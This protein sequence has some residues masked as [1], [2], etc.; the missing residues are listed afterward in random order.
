MLIP[1][2]TEEAA[3][4]AGKTASELPSADALEKMVGDLWK[5]DAQQAAATA[6]QNADETTET[7]DV[8]NGNTLV[9]LPDKTLPYTSVSMIFQGG[10]NMISSDDQGLSALLGRLLTK[11]T[12]KR[13]ALQIQ[14]FLAAH[15]ANLNASANREHFTV[16]AKFPTRFSKEVLGLFQEVLTDPTLSQE[17][18]EREK[19]SQIAEI[20]SREDKPLGLAF[21]HVFPFLFT[22]PPYTYF[23]L[24]TTEGVQN[25][26]REQVLELW[27]KQQHQKWVMAVCGD[28]DSQAIKNLATSLSALRDEDAPAA[29]DTVTPSW[30]QTT[31]KD[32]TLPNRNQSHL[33]L[34]FKAPSLDDPDTPALMLL[35]AALS[36]QSGLLFS[37]LRDEQGLGYSVSAFLWQNASAGFLAFYMGTSP[38]KSDK[39]LKGFDS[40][41]ERLLSSPLP[42]KD[43]QRGKNMLVGE[44]YRDNQSLNSRSTEAAMLL[45]QGYSLNLNRDQLEKVKS[46]TPEELLKVTQKYLVRK[47]AY[48][49]RVQP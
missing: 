3:A 31:S 38:D 7:I 26:T 44:Y 5:K 17:E 12:S 22:T 35:R 29:P 42:E 48:L 47:D 39:A 11:G 45:S 49:M 8:G 41:V 6:E 24:G 37:D 43:L 46:I 9:L 1:G 16:S 36:G 23:H 10:D 32:L 25:L 13:N 21:R 19:K 15:A 28:F 14:E 30:S 18:L 33:L 20:I 34:I 40:V 4:D 2:P 27:K